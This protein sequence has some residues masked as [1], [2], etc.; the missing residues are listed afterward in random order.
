MNHAA[1]YRKR[2][3]V[4]NRTI[5]AV[6]WDGDAG[7]ANDFLGERYGV[8]WEYAI[9]G[10]A[11]VFR[12]LTGRVRLEEGDWIIKSTSGGF[13]PCVAAVFEAA[14]ELAPMEVAG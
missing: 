4:S 2:S 7:T 9:G 3:R 11:I 6:R 10:G 8:D 13:Q 14:Y 1:K 5:E 12:T